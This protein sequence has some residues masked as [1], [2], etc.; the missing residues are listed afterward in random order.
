MFGFE[1]ALNP[2][3]R[4]Y[5]L[6]RV[7]LSFKSNELDMIEMYKIE[8]FLFPVPWRYHKQVVPYDQLTPFSGR[9]SVSADAPTPATTSINV[10]IKILCARLDDCR[11]S[12]CCQL[13][14]HSFLEELN[15]KVNSADALLCQLY[16]LLKKV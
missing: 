2:N 11:T 12:S 1:S 5:H 3:E 14:L 10:P 4:H 13:Y 6:K 15:P 8:V 16:A 9:S 7:D